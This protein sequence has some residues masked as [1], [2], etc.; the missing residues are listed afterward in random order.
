MRKNRNKGVLA[1]DAGYPHLQLSVLRSQAGWYIGT[2]DEDCCPVSRE[3]Q[4][5]ATEDAARLALE[6][7]NWIQRTTA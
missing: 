6:A 7:G 3:S 1:S 5:F 2:E 4:Y